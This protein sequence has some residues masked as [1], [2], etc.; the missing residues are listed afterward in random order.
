VTGADRCICTGAEEIRRLFDAEQKHVAEMRQW[1]TQKESLERDNDEATKQI[2][3]LEREL[4]DR[5]KELDRTKIEKQSLEKNLAVTKQQEEDLQER[6]TAA[7]QELGI[8]RVAEQ[9]HKVRGIDLALTLWVCNPPENLVGVCVYRTS[10]L[11]D[12]NLATYLT[13]V[14]WGVLYFCWTLSRTSETSG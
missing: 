9:T 12:A 3:E 14:W 13:A 4:D 8:R 1:L 11:H 10:K 5:N 2:D 7:Q 6:L